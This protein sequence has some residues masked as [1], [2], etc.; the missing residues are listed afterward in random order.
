MTLLTSLLRMTTMCRH[1]FLNPCAEDDYVSSSLQFVCV[2]L[3]LHVVF[4][5]KYYRMVQ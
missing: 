4:G 3:L 2:V 5:I 1:E